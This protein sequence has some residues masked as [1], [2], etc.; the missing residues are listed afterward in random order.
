MGFQAGGSPYHTIPPADVAC[1]AE[2]WNF[3]SLRQHRSGSLDNLRLEELMAST[4]VSTSQ[5]NTRGSVDDSYK[6]A[7]AEVL[8]RWN[9]LFARAEVCVT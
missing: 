3:T 2:S 1:A 8:H 6:L 9:L 7:Y 5:N 4:E